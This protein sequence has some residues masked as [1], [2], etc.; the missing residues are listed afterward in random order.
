MLSKTKTSI[1][2]AVT[3]DGCLDAVAELVVESRPGELS[4]YQADRLR[5][6]ATEI[7]QRLTATGFEV[8][9]GFVT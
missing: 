2:A 9:D 6:F 5:Q 3:L 1:Q 8:E 7:E 4:Q